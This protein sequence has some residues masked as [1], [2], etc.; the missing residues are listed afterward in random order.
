VFAFRTPDWLRR[1]TAPGDLSYGIYV[2]AFP[3]QQSVAAI[4]HDVDPLVMFAIA[5]PVTYGLAF[6]SWRLIERPAL[7]L[8]RVVAP[9]RPAKVSAALAT[10]ADR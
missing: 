10:A 6:V 5:F 7:A 2:Y 3:V 8:K 4:W 9:R 1:L